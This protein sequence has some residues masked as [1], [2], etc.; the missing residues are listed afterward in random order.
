[1]IIP[2]LQG[3][4]TC[5]NFFLYAACDTEYFDEFGVSLINSVQRNTNDGLHLHLYNPT[6]SQLE[7]CK[8]KEVSLSYEFVPLSLFNAAA[9]PWQCDQLSE[10]RQHNKQRIISA[11]E[12]GRDASIQQRMQRTYFACARFLRLNELTSSLRSCFAIDIDAVVRK[13]IDPLP[14]TTDLYIHFIPGKKQRFLAGGLYFTGTPGSKK[15]LENYTHLLKL[16]IEQDEIH[17][18]MDQ[19]LLFDILSKSSWKNLPIA[20]IDW[21]M[22]KNSYIWTAKGTR[23]EQDVFVNEKLKYVS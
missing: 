21:Y 23:K 14:A 20:Y 13:N 17:W 7:I 9:L 8:S 5:E 15:I 10:E 2:P 18:G 3:K 22:N 1:M 11:M 4:L 12:K 16:K 19:D 6:D